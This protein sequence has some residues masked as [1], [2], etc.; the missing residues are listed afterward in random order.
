MI[1]GLDF[2]CDSKGDERT[3]AVLVRDILHAYHVLI[4][5][6]TE[7][8]GKHVLVLMCAGQAHGFGEMVATSKGDTS[9]GY[10]S[11]VKETEMVGFYA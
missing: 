1:V 2:S 6:C 10:L 5:F 11:E 8:R 4:V 7:P 9:W 3:V